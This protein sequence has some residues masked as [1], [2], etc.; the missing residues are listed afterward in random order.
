MTRFD[1]YKNFKF[2]IKWEGRYVAG[3]RTISQQDDAVTLE[4][5][6]SDDAEFEQWAETRRGRR[7]DDSRT[8]F[9]LEERDE[10]GA[11]R[12]SLTLRRSWV[13]EYQA[14]PDLDASANAVEI[15]QLKIEPER[16]EVNDGNNGETV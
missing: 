6:V 13:S 3:F 5:G 11:L 8:N 14:L 4:G 7:D 9:V 2:L 15:Q 1:P 16:L 10:E 12:R